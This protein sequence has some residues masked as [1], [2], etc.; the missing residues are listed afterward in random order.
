MPKITTNIPEE[1]YDAINEYV[2][3]GIFNSQQEAVLYAVKK[4]YAQKSR[5]YL[6]WLMKKEKIKEQDLLGE[7]KKI[8]K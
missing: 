2:K 4:S 7:F 3:L 1:L 8:R 5:S 6:K